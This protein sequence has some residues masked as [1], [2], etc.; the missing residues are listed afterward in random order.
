MKKI[1]EFQE[2]VD[3]ESKTR[4]KGLNEKEFRI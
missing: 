3:R 2:F 4:T 1:L